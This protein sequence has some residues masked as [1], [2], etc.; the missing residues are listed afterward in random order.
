[1]IKESE[2]KLKRNPEL[3]LLKNQN[4]AEDR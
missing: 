2:A 3:A 1:M 4:D